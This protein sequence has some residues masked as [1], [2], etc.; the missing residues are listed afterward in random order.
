MFFLCISAYQPVCSFIVTCFNPLSIILPFAL[1]KQTLQRT[2]EISLKNSTVPDQN[3]GSLSS[4]CM[5]ML[6]F[7]NVP[8]P[9]NNYIVRCVLGK[10]F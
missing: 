10:R 3:I 2:E 5:G 7:R 1:N 6:C 8:F 4:E 9:M